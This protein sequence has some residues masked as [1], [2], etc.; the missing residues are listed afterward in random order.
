VEYII[1]EKL[2]AQLPDEEKKLW[3]SHHHEV[4]SGSLI[5]PGIPQV[6]EHELMEKLASTYG[7]TIHTWHTD[8]QRTLP[9]GAPMIMMG[10]TKDGQLRDELLSA[11]DERF[12]IS[13]EDIRKNR[14]DIPMPKVDPL[15]NAW[16]KGEVW[17]VVL[18]NDPDSA[19]HKHQGRPRTVL[20]TRIGCIKSEN[21]RGNGVLCNRAS[22]TSVTPLL[23]R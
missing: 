13:T 6:A 19:E 1:S 14:A 5:A 21:P 18:T 11:R 9:L 2:F 3:H 8:Q 10:F 16:E 17:Q 4:K 7:K 20:N 15:A 23:T 22:F 12:D